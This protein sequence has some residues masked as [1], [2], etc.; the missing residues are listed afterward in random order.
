WSSGS[1]VFLNWARPAPGGA[2][3]A[4][5][6]EAG[7]APG[8]ANLAI[9]STGSTATSF[10][11]SGVGAGTYYVRVKA[12][13]AAG[14]SAASNEAPL[15][16]GGGACTAAPVAPSGFGLTVNSGGTVSF[17]WNGSGGA[18]TS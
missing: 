6:I 3:S 8:L 1:S 17:A 7:S 4:Y 12:T 14:T 18:T 15:V 5:S 11:T 9:F 16:V 2:P 10:G 13:N